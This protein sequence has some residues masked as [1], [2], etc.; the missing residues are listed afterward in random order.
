MSGDDISHYMPYVVIA[1][2]CFKRPRSLIQTAALIKKPWGSLHKLWRKKLFCAK[3]MTTL[4]DLT[5]LF[6]FRIRK[7][8]VSSIRIHHFLYGLFPV[9]QSS[10]VGT[11]HVYFYFC[12]T[13]KPVPYAPTPFIFFSNETQTFYKQLAVVEVFVLKIPVRKICI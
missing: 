13:D 3:S 4:G 1:T 5:V 9:C 11:I 6:F 8:L 2:K 10:E 12:M 7:F